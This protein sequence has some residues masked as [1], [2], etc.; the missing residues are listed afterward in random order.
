MATTTNYSWTTPDDT[1]LVKD[2]ASAIRSL[3]TA[4]DSTVFTN[5]GNA[6]EKSLIDAEGDLIVGDASD[7]VQRLAVGSDGQVLTVDTSVDGKVKWAAPA[8][9]GDTFAAGKN[10]LINGDFAI[11]QRGF[12]S[13][14]TNGA[15]GFDRYKLLR[16][17]GTT[18]YSAETFTLGTAPVAGYE[19]K[20][21]ARIVSSGQ[22]ATGAYSI[23]N[24]T[25]ESVR[26]FAGQTATFS[27]WAKAS[28][29]TPSIAV[30][31]V[32]N[33]GTGGSPSSAVVTPVSKQEITTSWAR[34]SFTATFPSISGKTIGTNNNDHL[35]IN[36][37]TSAG[38]DLATDSSSLGIQSA[39]IDLWGWQLEAGSTATD[40][41]TATGTLQGELAACQRYFYN[42][43]TGN[44]FTIAM[45][46]YANATNVQFYTKFPV[47]MRTTPS[48]LMA[49]GTDYYQSSNGSDNF[50][51]GTINQAHTNGALIFNNSEVSGTSGQSTM[52]IAQNASSSIS[53]SA[54]L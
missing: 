51:S 26:T 42:H 32:Q 44:T 30:S 27:V 41:Q 40:F 2:G 49:S 34:Y 29:G 35:T 7:A 3:G 38:T 8:S 23:L 47:T 21:F 50:N 43:V 46:Y 45:G 13:T 11:N 1:D 19:A 53:F 54:E 4:I 22:T 39:T 14:T 24:G 9:G 6:V 28:T 15:Y 31:F 48:L 36:L 12:T 20:N 33:F 18:T 25:V 17:D 10:K 52:I 5:A 16:N 37:F